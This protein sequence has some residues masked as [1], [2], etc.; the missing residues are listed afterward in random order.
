M[1][2]LQKLKN[3]QKKEEK[4]RKPKKIIRYLHLLGNRRFSRPSR[5]QQEQL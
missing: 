2:H 5:S 3:K 1:N 4:K